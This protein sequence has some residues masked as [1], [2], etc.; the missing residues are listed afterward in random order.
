MFPFRRREEDDRRDKLL[1]DLAYIDL[2]TRRVAA[3][4]LYGEYRSRSRGSGV[5]FVEH[6]KYT[7]GEDYRQIDWSV[8]ARTRQAFV[9]IHHA[10]KEMAA[11]LVADLSGS[12]DQGTSRLTK[13]EV[14]IEAAVTIAFSAAK[15]HMSVGL[16]AGS[17]RADTYL[18]PR[19]RLRQAWRVLD[20]LL[21]TTPAART[22]NLEALIRF[23]AARLRHPS[24]LFLLSDFIGAERVV[25]GPLLA[26]L[27]Q[28]HD[29]VPVLVED[30][31]ERRWPSFR[32][33]LRLEDLE[34]HDSGIVSLTRDNCREMQARMAERR[35]QLRL[36]FLRLGIVPLVLNTEASPRGLLMEYF[37]KRKKQHR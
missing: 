29:V 11:F 2:R 19:K 14:L 33:Y 8:L 23:A 27:A 24:M 25:E 12:M 32:G 20:A 30:H 15:S 37:L 26:H 34:T 13:K 35:H 3:H 18:R 36:A 10:E 31:L 9:K 5:D 1:R 16:V 7:I 17:D 22:T 6:R 21:D 4:A 28:H